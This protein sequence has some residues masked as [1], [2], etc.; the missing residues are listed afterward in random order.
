M[1]QRLLQGGLLCSAVDGSG[2]M[3]VRM[4]DVLAVGLPPW[5][6]LLLAGSPGAGNVVLGAATELA[7]ATTTSETGR[8][9]ARE[10]TG[11]GPTRGA[12][13]F[14]LPL[15]GDDVVGL[16]GSRLLNLVV[17]VAREPP[18]P[19]GFPSSP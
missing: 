7:W 8:Y 17:A 18:P 14:G 3:A 9:R 19:P 2:A 1:V 6:T 15:S 5:L 12:P 10:E 4:M 16:C 13:R 11:G